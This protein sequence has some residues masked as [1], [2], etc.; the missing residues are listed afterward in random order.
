[1][2]LDSRRTEAE[3]VVFLDANMPDVRGCRRDGSCA[4]DET[5]FCRHRFNPRVWLIGKCHEK[6]MM[7]MRDLGV[8][9][10]FIADIRL[11]WLADG[12]AASRRFILATHDQTFVASARREYGRQ[13]HA[14]GLYPLTFGESWIRSGEGPSAVT[15]EVLVIAGGFHDRDHDLNAIRTHS[16][17][18]PARP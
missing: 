14:C 12:G 10:E 5:Y 3:V 17:S 13:P 7:R 2:I 11:R 15:V 6:R 16:V 8:V 1:L 18:L 4:A 9:C